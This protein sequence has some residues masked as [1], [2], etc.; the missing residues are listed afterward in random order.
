MNSQVGE[1]MPGHPGFASSEPL[2]TDSSG[3]EGERRGGL[4]CF[5]VV[6]LSAP[7]AADQG[8]SRVIRVSLTGTAAGKQKDVDT[9]APV[10]RTLTL[11]CS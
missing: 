4:D 6:S 5:T 7:P 10:N 9:S 8:S 11:I 3:K 1:Q 2:F